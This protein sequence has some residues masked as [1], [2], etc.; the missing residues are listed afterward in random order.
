MATMDT[1]KIRIARSQL[2]R[3]KEDL[4]FLGSPQLVA[5]LVDQVRAWTATT[6]TS[7][8]HLKQ[9]VRG[10]FAIDYG[11][12]H[13]TPPSSETPV[14]A[15]HWVWWL[16]A[17]GLAVVTLECGFAAIL[18]LLTF[19]VAPLWAFLAGV[20]MTLFITL[21]VKAVWGIL[22]SDEQRPRKTLRVLSRQL[23]VIFPAWLMAL[24]GALL[25]GR[26]VTEP[27]PTATLLFLILMTLLTM[28]SPILAS[29]LLSIAGLQ[30]WARKHVFLWQGLEELEADVHK[31]EAYAGAVE[32]RLGAE[33]AKNP[34]RELVEVNERLQGEP[35][36]LR[37]ASLA[38]TA[39][40]VLLLA[41]P[42]SKAANCGSEFWVDGSGSPSKVERQAA[43][44]H[45]LEL[46]P[47]WTESECGQDWELF[48]FAGQAFYTAPFLT[49]HLS[50]QQSETCE[51]QPPTSEM[52]VIF[53]RVAKQAEVERERRCA[54]KREGQASAYDAAIALQISQAR[55]RL[56]GFKV[57]DPDHTCIV[58]LLS[59]LADPSQTPPR[60]ALIVTDGEET[61][62]PSFQGPIPAPETKTAV[63]M[64]IISQE[65]PKLTDPRLYYLRMKANWLKLAP[66]IKVVPAYG[67]E[68]KMFRSALDRAV[69]GGS[70]N[71]FRTNVSGNITG[72]TAGRRERRSAGEERGR[73]TAIGGKSAPA[74]RPVTI[75][76]LSSMR[77][78]V[79][80]EPTLNAVR[81]PH[82]ATKTTPVG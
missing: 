65:K 77:R 46:L 13:G 6:L 74:V 23:V 43:V 32:E 12:W 67:I 56:A 71:E 68:E 37:E 27:T 31:L 24:T 26:V 16:R 53:R 28:L 70:T 5:A 39:A 1:Q 17:S 11:K 9:Q 4:E 44:D 45:F 80:R 59:R 36:G 41:C 55:E 25:L 22:F 42:P 69:A 79:W 33:T 3:F 78:T 61:C 2:D 51:I 54:E 21:V 60:R 58:D 64:V 76:K 30:G 40:L 20:L 49:I 15:S 63:A 10:E 81:T 52:P 57:A 82:A 35:V 19:N 66:W 48:A 8:T 72:L 34:D 47:Q 73:V 14:D 7:I 38:A 18:G 75:C 29:I 62:D 50:R